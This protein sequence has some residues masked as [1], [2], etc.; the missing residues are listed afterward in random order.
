MVYISKYYKCVLIWGEIIL[1]KSVILMVAV[2]V[3]VSAYLVITNAESS[4]GDSSKTSETYLDGSSGITFTLYDDMTAE[5]TSLT[6]PQKKLTVPGTVEKDGVQYTVTSV[7]YKFGAR[8]TTVE[9]IVFAASITELKGASGSYNLFSIFLNATKL[10][11]VYFEEGSKLTS[12]GNGAFSA[13]IHLE[14]IVLPEGLTTIGKNV[15]TYTTASSYIDGKNVKLYYN[16]YSLEKLVLPSTLEKIGEGSLPNLAMTIELAEGNKSFAIENGILYDAGKTVLIRAFD[17][18]GDITIPSTVKTIY[19]NAFNFQTSDVMSESVYKSKFIWFDENPVKDP[20]IGTVTIPA[21]VTS[22]GS[23]AFAL[24]EIGDGIS[25]TP[26]SNLIIPSKLDADLGS[27]AFA[28][29]PFV[30]EM[31]IGEG[32]TVEA[33]AYYGCDNVE[34][35]YILSTSIEARYSNCVAKTLILSDKLTNIQAYCLT[36]WKNLSTVSYVGAELQEGVAKLPPSLKTIGDTSFEGS[37]FE[38]LDLSELS[39]TISNTVFNDLAKLETIEFGNGI[40]AIGKNCFKNLTSLKS[41][42]IPTSVTEVGPNSFRGCTALTEIIVPDTTKIG[43]KV[44]GDSVVSEGNLKVVK[45]TIRSSSGDKVIKTVVGVD[46]PKDADGKITDSTVTIP[47]EVI[48]IRGDALPDNGITE[49]ILEEGNDVYILKDHV[50]YTKD[51]KTLVFVLSSAIGSDGIF[52][53]P[54]PVTTLGSYSLSYLSNLK[55]VVCGT[56]ASLSTIEDHVFYQSSIE[57]FTAPVGLK[58]IGDSAFSHSSIKEADLSGV[59]QE[60][61]IGTF[62]FMGS[63]LESVYFPTAQRVII[64][65]FSFQKT[66]LKSFEIQYGTVGNSAFGNCSNL[67]SVYLGAG[68]TK[69]GIIFLLSPALK[70]VAILNTDPEVIG[71]TTIAPQILADNALIIVPEDSAADYS[72]FEAKFH[73]AKLTTLANGNSFILSSMDGIEFTKTGTTDDSVSYTFT[74][75]P[76]YDRSKVTV[77]IDGSD[78]EVLGNGFT[79]KPTGKTQAVSVNG[80]ELNKYN[81]KVNIQNATTTLD[82]TEVIHGDSIMF[83]I[84]PDVGY[85]LK[86]VKAV[87]NGT[88]YNALHESWITIPEITDDCEIEIRGIIPEEYTVSFMKDGKIVDTSTATFGQTFTPSAVSASW[89]LYDSTVA[90]DFSQGIT[91]DILFFSSPVS[92]DSKVEIDYYAPRGS[93]SASWIGGAVNSGETLLRGS[94]VTFSYDGDGCYS[95]VGWFIDGKFTKTTDVSITVSNVTKS[96]TAQVAVM[97][98][99]AGYKYIVNAPMVLP[100]EEYMK[101]LWIGTY[102]DPLSKDYYAN[103]PSGYTVMGDYLF[104]VSGKDLIRLDLNADFSNGMPANSIK[105]TPEEV[106]ATIDYYGGYIFNGTHV[107]DLELNY[108]FDVE[109]TPCGMHD[110][111][112]VSLANNRVTKYT[113]EQKDGGYQL[114]TLWSLSLEKHYGKCFIEGDYFYHLSVSASDSDRAIQSIDLVNGTIKDT[115]NINQWQYGHYYDDGWLTVYD[116]WAYI[117]SYT[118]GLFGETNPYVTAR[119]PVL[120]RVAIKDG[121]FDPNSVQTMV[122]PNNTQQSGLIVYNG[123]GY[124]NSGSDLVVI[125]MDS[126]TMI[127]KEAGTKTHGGIVLNTYYATPENGYKVYI[128]VVPYGG[129]ETIWVYTDDQNKTEAGTPQKIE[130]TGYSQYATTHIRTSASGY[131]YWYNDSSIFFITGQK[132]HEVSFIVDGRELQKDSQAV[133]GTAL[134]IPDAPTKSGYTFVG[135]YNYNG[136]PISEGAVVTGDMTIMAIYQPNVYKVVFAGNDGALQE[137]EYKY[138]ELPIYEGK[139]PVKIATDKCTYV[140]VGWDS[141]IEPVSGD[142]T[143]TAVWEAKDRVSTKDDVTE[144]DLS[145]NESSFILTGGEKPID[146]KLPDN[147]SAMILDSTSLQGKTISAD[148][149]KIQNSSSVKGSAFEFTLTVDGTGY[150][151]KVHVTLPYEKVSGKNPVVYFIDG[152]KAVEMKIISSTDSSVTFETDHNSV[153]VVS[154]ESGSSSNN[155]PIYLCVATILLFVCI[156]GVSVA[157]KRGQ[158]HQ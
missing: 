158:A 135:W 51:M 57:S 43:E 117:A 99:Q 45:I 56:D 52:T 131:I 153:Y 25:K 88:S 65:N 118:Q 78:I 66:N 119:T 140:F 116:G 96:V 113:I 97:Y 26:Y 134:T 69:I 54:D 75:S 55:A 86:D 24:Y 104:M 7:G 84:F 157:R 49:I 39:T 142:V 120:L 156:A 127:Y 93:I 92:D 62:A 108:L 90:Y 42:T 50:L 87:I 13:C 150:N 48:S 82:L 115:V 89:Y 19:P 139:Q 91:Q 17:P 31:Y 47:K 85:T 124:I 15:L 138:G 12:I 68:V 130:G 14:K 95:V 36:A 3:S 143:Y 103:M 37:V 155:T 123:R 33:D 77:S 125:D 151:G 72:A 4:V 98:E 101:M 5:A 67:E 83:N 109:V 133:N 102:N 129:A 70:Y 144:I 80:V 148:M 60:L 2:L 20:S 21:S 28:C 34:V 132:Y 8:D 79:V 44:F 74:L 40:T 73:L 111:A 63:Q 46:L 94:D 122:L 1:K 145:G 146:L 41:L 114:E 137:S 105:V 141:T 81:V 11:S 112:F 154:S 147:S 29:N 152:D 10:K 35:A 71:K 22:I 59:D 110:G 106:G 128:Y 38:H 53:I 64:G 32:R 107:Y 30:K 9:E 27:R 149:K 58:E 23:Y 76:A 100:D 61:T 18:T 6:V 136:T 16:L 126:F 121:V